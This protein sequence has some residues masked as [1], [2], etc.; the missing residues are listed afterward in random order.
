[1]IPFSGCFL[2]KLL[3]SVSMI[4]KKHALAVQIIPDQLVLSDKTRRPEDCLSVHVLCSL[5]LL[6]IPADAGRGQQSLI[7]ALPGY[8]LLAHVMVSEC[9]SQCLVVQVQ[10]E[11][12]SVD[13]H[14][15][16]RPSLICLV[17]AS[18]QELLDGFE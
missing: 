9:S 15:R 18:F 10:K 3:K 2:L 16:R 1:M 14:G 11:F 7:V 17:I 6:L 12:R 8:I 5:S 13:K 4:F